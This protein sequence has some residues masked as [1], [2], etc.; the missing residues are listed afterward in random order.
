M[1]TPLELH[2]ATVEP[3]CMQPAYCAVGGGVC[4]WPLR[5]GE[6]LLQHDRLLLRYCMITI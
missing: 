1:V 4:V 3:D 6:A 2:V 5:V